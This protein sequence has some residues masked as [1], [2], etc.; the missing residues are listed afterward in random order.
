MKTCADILNEH[1]AARQRRNPG[2]S[3]RAYS[4]DLKV[5]PGTLSSVLNGKR[6]LPVKLAPKI[7]ERLGLTPRVKQQFFRAIEQSRSHLTTLLT[8][9]TSKTFELDDTHYHILAEWEHY[10]VLTL[11]DLKTFKSDVAW[12]AKRLNI[13]PARV[14]VVLQ[15]LEEAKLIARN[16]KDELSPVHMRLATNDSVASAALRAAHGEELDLAK[17]ALAEIPRELRDFTSAT[18]NLHPKHLPSAKEAIKRFRRELTELVEGDDATDVF[19]L[20]IQLFPLTDV[21]S[22]EGINT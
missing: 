9:T 18:M 1:L 17:K 3:L 20:C 12:I 16:S 14:K 6:T 4:R 22:S 15:R 7:A 21:E 2:Y 5:H 11:M 8:E 19:Q 13:S 10:A